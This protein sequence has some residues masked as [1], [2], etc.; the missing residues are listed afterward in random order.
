MKGFSD[1]IGSW[2]IMPIRFPR[3][4]RISLSGSLS[5]SLPSKI[6][7]PPAMRPG[8]LGMS[9]MID[10][11]VT[12]L[13]EPDSPTMPSV[14]PR[15]TSNDTPSTALTTRPSSSKYVRR[16]LTERSVNFFSFAD[17]ARRAGRLR[18]S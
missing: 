13:P 12:D 17:R 7:S 4:A 6:T 18:E 5:R 16:F 15:N 14:S 10:R 3:I 1:V 9:R 8:G 11:L 2:K